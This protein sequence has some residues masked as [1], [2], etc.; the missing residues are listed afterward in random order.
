MG[1]LSGKTAVVTGGTRGLGLAIATAFAR[2][3][4]DVV[5]AS[6]SQ[7]SVDEAVRRLKDEGAQAAG[8]PVNV[9]DLGQVQGLANLALGKFGRLDIWVNNAGVAGPYGPTLD[10]DPRI[11]D[12]VVDT[13]IRGV[14]NGSWT[15]MRHFVGERSGKLI[16]LLGRG[17]DAPVPWQNAYSSSKA[18]VRS[19]TMALAEETRGSGVGIF[20]FN[21]GMVLTDLLTDVEVIEGSEEKL[22]RFPYIVRL[23]ASPPERPA[24]KVVWIASPATDGKTGRLIGN[25]SLLTIYGY[26][27]CEGLRQMRKEQGADQ[28]I[29]MRTVARYRG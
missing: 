2:A 16:N 23:L 26:L 21:P 3:G 12:Q 18:W 6:R 24:R 8:L 22:K 17:Y 13:N 28:E 1:V 7:K 20:A 11:F 27:I 14:Y 15:A 4:A 5:V 10:S 19:F 9:A 29:R 25:S